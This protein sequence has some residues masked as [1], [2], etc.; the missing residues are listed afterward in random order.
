MTISQY[1]D[2]HEHDAVDES[3]VEV[4]IDEDAS[5]SA[6]VVETAAV[7]LPMRTNAGQ[8]SLM[9][10]VAVQTLTATTM[11]TVFAIKSQ[12]LAEL[13]DDIEAGE[14]K[15]SELVAM[16]G[17]LE[18]R[19]EELK[20]TTM[21]E[22]TRRQLDDARWRS[23]HDHLLEDRKALR[24]VVN[25]LQHILTVMPHL[26]RNEIERVSTINLARSAT[27]SSSAR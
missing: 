15:R 26:V 16:L 13:E 17:E 22:A 27:A 11:D 12:A 8:Q 20:A 25:S 7:S 4:G 3:C 10:D 24:S 9:K 1:D 2:D 14:A 19:V 5:S 23:L 21:D 18:Q 6:S